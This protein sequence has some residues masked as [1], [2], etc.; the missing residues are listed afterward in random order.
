[1]SYTPN[2]DE[3]KEACNS[4]RLEHCFRYLFMQEAEENEGFI[5]LLREECDTVRSRMQK[6]RQLLEEG[7][8]FSPFDPVAGDGLKCMQDAQYKDGH[9][10][11]A[12][13]VVLDYALEA[14]DEKAEHV[15][16]MEQYG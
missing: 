4:N 9:I 15:T 6:R 5:V 3:L 11:A 8:R 10:L 7:Q 1:M 14:R 2:F 13:N 16:T 12:L